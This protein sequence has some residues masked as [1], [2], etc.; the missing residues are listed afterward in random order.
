M[1]LGK[2][3][4]GTVAYLGGVMSL[5]EPFVWS[6]SQMLEYNADY[7]V[8]GNERIHYDRATV[9]Y[10]SFARNSLV[11][12]MKGDWIFML[13]T[14]LKFEPDALTRM[15]NLMYK[16]NVDVVTGLYQFKSHPYSP[17]MYISH[18]GQNQ[19]LGK[20]DDK[21]DLIEIGS[22]GAGCL[23]IKSSVIKKI[24]DSKENAFDIIAPF[25]EDHSFFKR[26]RKLKIKAYCA[27]NI[28]FRHLTFKEVTLDDYD[29][30]GTTLSK[31]FTRGALVMKNI[32]GGE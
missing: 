15:V 14:D 28:H 2:K 21:V 22:S 11:D 1:L 8:Q 3:I 32:E 4:I 27:P 5:P 26:L 13:D 10:H 30:E 9:S 31:K 17:V 18:K 23:L 20:W 25:S 12:R 6:W 19:M 24:K 7:L 16:H 29:T